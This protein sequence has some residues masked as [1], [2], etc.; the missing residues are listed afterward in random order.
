MYE[1]CLKAQSVSWLLESSGEA[2][3]NLYQSRVKYIVYG[4]LSVSI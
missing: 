1:G 2:C 4:Y 3:H